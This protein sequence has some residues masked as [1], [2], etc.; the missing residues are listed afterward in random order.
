MKYNHMYDIAF[1]VDTDV[2]DPFKVPENEL[3]I[4][5]LRRICTLLAEGGT[6]GTLGFCVGE[7]IDHC[8]SYEK[9]ED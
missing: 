6:C 8:D 9:E 7:A 5:L 4:G 2:E 1:S 3:M